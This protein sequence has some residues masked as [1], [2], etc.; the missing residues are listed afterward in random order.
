[1][2]RL[3]ATQAPI[4]PEP[5]SVRIHYKEWTS[6][7]GGAIGTQGVWEMFVAGVRAEV[8]LCETEDVGHEFQSDFRPSEWFDDKRPPSFEADQ[9]IFG[10]KNCRYKEGG[11]SVPGRFSCDGVD[12]F[13]CRLSDRPKVECKEVFDIKVFYG[14]VECV[15]PVQ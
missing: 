14:M 4:K 9:A 7:W 6:S 13:D 11:K 3:P 8:D 2:D 15:F 5:F 10:R 12:E 1:M